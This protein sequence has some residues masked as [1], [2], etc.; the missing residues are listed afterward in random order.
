[1]ASPLSAAHPGGDGTVAASA[2]C[3]CFSSAV[4]TAWWKQGFWFLFFTGPERNGRNSGISVLFGFQNLNFRTKF[5]KIL[6]FQ[7]KNMQNSPNSVD[8]VW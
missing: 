1:M 3:G 7:N 2:M 4:Q 8:F 6:N 5:D